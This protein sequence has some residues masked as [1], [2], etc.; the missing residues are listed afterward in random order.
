MNMK[1]KKEDFE[2]KL[3]KWDKSELREYRKMIRAN[4]KK[5]RSAAKNFKPY[6][7]GFAL[8]MLKA[9]LIYMNDYFSQTVNVLQCDESRLEIE[10]QIKTALK[11]LDEYEELSMEDE[12]KSVDKI[13][14]FF[15]YVG[16]HILEWWD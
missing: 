5:L 14:E 4:K 8:S 7:Y 10:N 1:P 3:P 13:K 9:I 15:S 6:D 2:Y 11:L 12:L 16:E